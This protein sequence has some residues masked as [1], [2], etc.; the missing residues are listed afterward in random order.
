MPLLWAVLS[1]NNGLHLRQCQSSL[2]AAWL[3]QYGEEKM[4]VGLSYSGKEMKNAANSS[5]CIIPNGA[6]G[7]SRGSPV[8][9][10]VSQ[11]RRFH[12]THVS[13]VILFLDSNDQF[14][15]ISLDG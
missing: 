13:P 1:A 4:A 5:A 14:S 11:R 2:Y 8:N 12:T 10:V 3:L 15:S 9:L 7:G 6:R